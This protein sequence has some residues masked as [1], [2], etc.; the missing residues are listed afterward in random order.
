MSELH[1]IIIEPLIT[2][3][4]TLLKEQNRVYCFKVRKDATKVDIKESVESIF[5]VEIEKVR[6][7]NF[8]GKEKKLG[9]N[10]GRRPNWKKAWVT[11]KPNSKTIEYFEGA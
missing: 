9:R 7:A 11:L 4:S 3:K 8:K 2:E 6:L 1:N 10:I 5:G